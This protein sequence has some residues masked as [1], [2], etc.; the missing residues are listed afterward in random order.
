MGIKKALKVKKG[1]PKQALA[2]SF[3][4]QGVYIVAGRATSPFS[5]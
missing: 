5:S 1:M 4:P 3:L 2:C